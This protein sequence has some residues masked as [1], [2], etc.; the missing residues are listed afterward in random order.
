V[1]EVNGL[2]SAALRCASLDGTNDSGKK[3]GW[4]TPF[5]IESIHT[6]KPIPFVQRLLPQPALG[7]SPGLGIAVLVQAEFRAGHHPQKRGEWA[8]RG[9]GT[10][11]RQVQSDGDRGEAFLQ[12]RAIVCA[13]KVSGNSP[14][15]AK[16]IRTVF[17]CWSTPK[18]LGCM[19][20]WVSMR[21]SPNIS[22]RD[23]SFVDVLEKMKARTHLVH[24]TVVGPRHLRKAGVPCNP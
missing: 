14:I 24:V 3:R 17:P 16:S 13:T 21:R 7:L 9:M 6:S 1:N 10:T 5:D 20:D 8:E 23:S 15:A 12:T 4:R 11:R 19:S 2:G 18:L 22:T